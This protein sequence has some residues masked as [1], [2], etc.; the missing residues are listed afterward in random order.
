MQI[1][2]SR[3]A[4]FEVHDLVYDFDMFLL[5][6]LFRDTSSMLAELSTGRNSRGG[7]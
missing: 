1:Q 3:L 6:Y 7:S 4:D 5:A 2:G